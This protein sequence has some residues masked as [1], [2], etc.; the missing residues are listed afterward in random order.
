MK[1]DNVDMCDDVPENVPLVQIAL[2]L[3]E[4]G[5]EDSRTKIR[6]VVCLLAEAKLALNLA[7]VRVAHVN[8]M[9]RSYQCRVDGSCV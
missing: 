6:A 1:L 7:S 3:L 2:K 5:V 9:K 4:P 8:V